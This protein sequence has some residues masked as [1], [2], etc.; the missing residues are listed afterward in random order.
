MRPKEGG[1]A[2]TVGGALD[3]A[4]LGRGDRT[5]RRYAGA[6]LDLDE[7]EGFSSL[8][9]NVHFADVGAARAFVLPLKDMPAGEAQV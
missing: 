9:D 7:C 2:N 3:A 4:S 5:R 1:A 8:C 6:G